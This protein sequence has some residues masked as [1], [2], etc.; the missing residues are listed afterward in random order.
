M[1]FYFLANFIRSQF[2]VPNEEMMYILK[3]FFSDI[4]FQEREEISLEEGKKTKSNL[5]EIFNI[6]PIKKKKIL[7][8]IKIILILFL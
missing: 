8:F 7:T 6:P 2:I 3:S 4:I 5:N 1:Y